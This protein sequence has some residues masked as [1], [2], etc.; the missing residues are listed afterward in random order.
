MIKWIRRI[1]FSAKESTNTYHEVDNR[2]F[3]EPESGG[4]GIIIRELK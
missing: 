1:V 4:A 3:F 2:M